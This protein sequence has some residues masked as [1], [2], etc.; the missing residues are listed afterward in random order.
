M[1]MRFLKRI[2]RI[3]ASGASLSDYFEYASVERA[4]TDAED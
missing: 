4:L 3:R 1:T 2:R